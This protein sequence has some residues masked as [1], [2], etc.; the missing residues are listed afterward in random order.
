MHF[1][2]MGKLE[3]FFSKSK[4]QWIVNAIWGAIGIVVV[5]IP[6]HEAYGSPN[7]K[8]IFSIPFF[9]IPEGFFYILEVKVGKRELS[10]KTFTLIMLFE[11]PMV[12]IFT[13]LLI[14]GSVGLILYFF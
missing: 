9:G 6:M 14:V 3:Y 13:G 1:R 4:V 12:C 5:L 10:M 2:R 8:G 11:G 7:W